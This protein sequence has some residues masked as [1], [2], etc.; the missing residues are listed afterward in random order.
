MRNNQ[1]NLSIMTKEENKMS[2]YSDELLHGLDEEQ[3]SETTNDNQGE[4]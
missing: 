2:K 1:V 3:S 4:K